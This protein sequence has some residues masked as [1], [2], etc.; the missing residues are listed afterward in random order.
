MEQQEIDI[1]SFRLDL[2]RG[3]LTHEGVEI[4]LK[5]K[6]LAILGALAQARGAVV[7]KDALMAQVWPGLVVEENNLQ[8]H[9]SA[10]RKVL[11][12]DTSGAVHLVTVPAKGYRLLG[13][14]HEG[15]PPP[16]AAG[17]NSQ[18]NRPSIAVLPFVH[19]GEDPAQEYF[20]DGVVEDIITGLSRVK[21]LSVVA[22][23]SSFAY[24]MRSADVAQIARE[25]D[26]RY[27]L[28]GSLR[29]ADDRIRISAHLIETAGNTQIWAE[30][31]DR[32]LGDLFA[33]QDEIAVSVVGAIEPGLR[34]AEVERIRRKRPDTLDAYDLVL[35]ALPY[36]YRLM[37]DSSAP[38]IPLLTKALELDPD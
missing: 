26:V 20:V 38:A 21:W 24:R 37:P 36:V 6:A 5:S 10:L 2:A 8:V 23:H 34:R 25:L 3:R 4:E 17:P 7:T 9:V 28:Q 1:G 35:R 27:L 19:L 22:S 13:V 16:V 33:L 31:F 11:A 30:R 32:R 29:R 14:N 18:A 12:Q 15:A